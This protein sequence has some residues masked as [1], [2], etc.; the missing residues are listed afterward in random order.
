MSILSLMYAMDRGGGK[1]FDLCRSA[2]RRDA[3][4]QS[5]DISSAQSSH[6]SRVDGRH[7]TE[8]TGETGGPGRS[9]GRAYVSE[10][11]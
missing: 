11:S 6:S 9:A 7:T 10:R 5:W 3:S 8:R 4:A 2:L 1:V